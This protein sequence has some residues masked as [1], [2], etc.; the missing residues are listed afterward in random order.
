MVAE[1]VDVRVGRTYVGTL[2]TDTRLNLF[3]LLTALLSALA[4]TGR[5]AA[6]RAAAV[7]ASRAVDVAQAVA[8]AA[9]PVASPRPD[10]Y[11]A[12]APLII[13][14]A[15]ARSFAIAITPERRRE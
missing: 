11:V 14:L 15:V 3:L 4:G 12:P 10:G 8:P 5:P 6:A 9:R 13:D 1:E 2:K 7:E